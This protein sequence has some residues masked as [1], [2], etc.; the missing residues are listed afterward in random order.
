MIVNDDQTLSPNLGLNS[1]VSFTSAV[2]QE[3]ILTGQFL[4]LKDEANAVLTVAL[5]AALEV[6]GLA[7]FVR[8]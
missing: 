2:H 8:F 3:A 7:L 5:D 1:W 4:L 6:T